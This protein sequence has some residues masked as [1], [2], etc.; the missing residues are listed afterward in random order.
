[1]KR[2]LILIAVSS[3][4][5]G[6]SP[7]SSAALVNGGFEALGGSLNGWTTGF[8]GGNGSVGAR[9]S[10]NAW[11]AIEGSY[12]AKLRTDDQGLNVYTTLRQ[13]LYLGVGD[14]V[15]LRYFLKH[16]PSLSVAEP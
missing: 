6:A 7:I 14:Q 8:G 12:F 15:S 13:E 11:T 9:M 2:L 5:I 3:L 10:A 16:R 4:L 1:M